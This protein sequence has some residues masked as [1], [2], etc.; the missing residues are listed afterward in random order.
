MSF[1]EVKNKLSQLALPYSAVCINITVAQTA[2]LARV[3]S[4]VASA[5]ASAPKHR[6]WSSMKHSCR[7]SPES[8]F[9]FQKNTI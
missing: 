8:T 6:V 3:D 2:Y 9:H 4:W 1:D 7:I 5:I